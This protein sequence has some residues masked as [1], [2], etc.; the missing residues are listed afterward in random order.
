M[1]SYSEF[2]C[3]TVGASECG[4]IDS[5]PLIGRTLWDSST[6]TIDWFCEPQTSGAAATNRTAAPLPEDC[7]LR[8]DR[9]NRQPA[10]QEKRG[11][12]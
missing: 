3:R 6:L 7:G 2:Q 9:Y 12:A 11:R 10:F 1:A 5:P 8:R 4:G